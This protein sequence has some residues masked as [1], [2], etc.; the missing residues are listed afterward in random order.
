MTDNR[1]RLD[2]LLD[3]MQAELN[4]LDLWETTPPDPKA[5]QSETP[6]FADTMK[7]TQWLQWVF[8]ARFRALLAGDHELPAQCDVAPLAEE[9]L[10]DL[11]ADTDPLV[12][13]I[14]EFDDYF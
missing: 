7:F 12:E 1:D 9:S 13:L 11:N 14:R 6:F 10:R 4:R 8:I 3:D 5:F 2:A